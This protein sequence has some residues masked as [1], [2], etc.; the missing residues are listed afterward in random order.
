MPF[1]V[2]HF[3]EWCLCGSPGLDELIKKNVLL[4]GHDVSFPVT[5]FFFPFRMELILNCMYIYF[6]YLMQ[7]VRFNN[8]R[9]CFFLQAHLSL[10]A[11]N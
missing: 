10:E 8:K 5:Y 6:P 11:L 9:I 1:G 2:H 4:K 3:S 7:N